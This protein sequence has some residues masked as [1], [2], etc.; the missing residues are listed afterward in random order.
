MSR[1]APAAWSG[2]HRFPVPLSRP[3]VHPAPA[4]QLCLGRGR[5]GGRALCRGRGCARL[6]IAGH[7]HFAGGREGR[8]IRAQGRR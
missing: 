3:L 7:D 6:R 4:L 1:G 2:G 5:A 8:G